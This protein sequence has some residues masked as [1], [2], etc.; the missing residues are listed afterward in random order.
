M[1]MF[2]SKVMHHVEEQTVNK[3]RIT[4]AFNISLHGPDKR[5]D[6]VFN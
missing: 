6:A 3:E 4:F 1:V 2:P 5:E